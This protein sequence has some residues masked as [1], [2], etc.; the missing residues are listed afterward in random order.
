MKM[1]RVSEVRLDIV[2]ILGKVSS[3][4]YIILLLKYKKVR[5]KF[6]CAFY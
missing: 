3:K 1:S 2:I 5:V 4:I 6:G